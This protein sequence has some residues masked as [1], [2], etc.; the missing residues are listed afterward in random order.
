VH[1]LNVSPRWVETM[2][3]RLLAGRDFVQTDKYPGSA[4]VNET[5]AKKYFPGENPIGKSFETSDDGVKRDRF[6]IVGLLANTRYQSIRESALSV[7]YVPLQ[8]AKANGEWDSLD[9]ASFIVR[10]SGD[11]PI[12][13]IPTLR[14]Q[15]LTLHPE[16][17]LSRIR[18]QTEIN[19]AQTV[20]ERLLALLALFFAVV[21]VL[22]AGSDSTEFCVTSSSTGN[23][24]LAYASLSGRRFPTLLA[25]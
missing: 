23:A 3:V 24:R 12:S 19:Q 20:H 18:T 7:V 17:R 2:N 6:E 21:A 14:Q 9:A 25:A 10:V 15:I 11:S 4:L 5:F 22:L 16:F 13:F 8:A 1:F